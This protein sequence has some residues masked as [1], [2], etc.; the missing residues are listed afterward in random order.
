MEKFFKKGTLKK[1]FEACYQNT[2]FDLFSIIVK[3]PVN[4]K[5]FLTNLDIIPFH[6]L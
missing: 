1:F 5:D 4:Y 6:R 3:R 2:D